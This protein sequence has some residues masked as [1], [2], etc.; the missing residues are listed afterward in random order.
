MNFGNSN[1][2][3]TR[4]LS[5]SARWLSSTRQPG[6]GSAVVL[7]ARRKDRLDAIVKNIQANGGK[8]L[9]GIVPGLHARDYFEVDGDLGSIGE[10]DVDFAAVGRVVVDAEVLDGAVSG[11]VRAKSEINLTHLCMLTML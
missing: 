5:G 11:F 6:F 7:G 4:W 2:S 10:G 1:R 8:A 3:S 9:S